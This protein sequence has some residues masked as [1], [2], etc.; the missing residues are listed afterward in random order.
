M[1][2][3]TIDSSVIITSLFENEPRHEEALRIWESI[4]TGRDVAIMPLYENPPLCQR[5]VKGGFSRFVV[6]GFSHKI[7]TGKS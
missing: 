2:R 3:L 5:G 7:P 4:I 1:K 6:P